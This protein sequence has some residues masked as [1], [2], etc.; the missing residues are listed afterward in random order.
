MIQLES[1]TKRFEG[2][3]QVVALD[4][5]DLSVARGEMVAIIGPS[6]SGK[7]TLLNLV[8]GLDRP[9]SGQVTVDGRHLSGLSDDELTRVRR[10]TIGFIFQFFNLLPSLSGF[11]NVALPLHLRGWPRRKTEARARELL[12]LVGLGARADH[13]P[14]ELSGGERQ[15]VAIARALSIYPPLLLADEPTGNLDTHTGAEILELIRDV[16]SRL[17]ATVLIV[18]HDLI[19]ARSSERTIT[20]RDGRIVED[21]RR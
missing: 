7:S 16:H 12:E 10:D 18:T 19:V 8:G 17:G 1:V 4:A 3:R 2:K 15:R 5:V 21:E 14:D 20:L 13:L 9:T 6:G 11:E